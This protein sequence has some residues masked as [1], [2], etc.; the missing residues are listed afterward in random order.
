MYSKIKE[1]DLIRDIR[2]VSV[3]K[4]RIIEITSGTYKG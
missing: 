4:E 3:G 1:P 2:N